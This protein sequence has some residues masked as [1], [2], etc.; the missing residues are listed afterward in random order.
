MNFDWRAAL[1]VPCREMEIDVVD[2]MQQM[3]T[4]DP[5]SEH[6]GTSASEDDL[7]CE[8][9]NDF[10]SDV[11]AMCNYISEWEWELACRWQKHAVFTLEGVEERLR[12]INNENT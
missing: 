4:E 5:I 8:L 7:A 3:A 12:E 9:V 6:F 2:K 10:F 11:N 1:S